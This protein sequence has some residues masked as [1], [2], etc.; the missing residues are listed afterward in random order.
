AALLERAR[1]LFGA[2]PPPPENPDNPF[3]DQKVELGR[4]LY[5]DTRLSKNHDLSCNSCHDLAAFGV[6]IRRENDKLLPTSKGHKDQLGER[7][8]PTVYNAAFHIAQFWD[9][10]AADIEEQ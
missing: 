8:S 3:T 5:F 7:N 1:P 4:M 2:L 9:G 10:R 6:D